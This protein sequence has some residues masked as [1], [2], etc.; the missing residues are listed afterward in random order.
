MSIEQLTEDN[1]ESKLKDNSPIIVDFWASWCGPCM[2]MSP[3]FEELSGDYKDKLTFGKVNTEEAPNVAS[4]NNIMS[5]PCLVVFK[6]GKEIDRIVGAM[7]K[8]ALKQKID[9]IIG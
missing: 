8:E 1:F 9:T 4:K 3:V 7:P 6:D 5:I 2:M